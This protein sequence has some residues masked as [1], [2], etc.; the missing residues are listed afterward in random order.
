MLGKI[1]GAMLGRRLVGIVD[2]ALGIEV[3]GDGGQHVGEL[4]H[5]RRKARVLTFATLEKEQIVSRHSH[6]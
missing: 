3:Q 6:G 2:D 5:G 4:A 1:A